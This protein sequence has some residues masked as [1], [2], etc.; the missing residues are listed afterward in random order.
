MTRELRSPGAPGTGEDSEALTGFIG[1]QKCHSGGADGQDGSGRHPG[2][3]DHPGGGSGQLGGVLNCHSPTAGM[4]GSA[5]NRYWLTVVMGCRGLAAG[6]AGRYVG[7]ASWG[8][9]FRRAQW[10]AYQ[11]RPPVLAKI[12]ALRW[13]AVS[14]ELTNPQANTKPI[15]L[16]IA[17]TA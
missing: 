2:S 3:G 1:A 16:D 6:A 15:H 7:P 11:M 12:S 8:L 13:A 5:S 9:R 4:S 14:I 10:T 17:R